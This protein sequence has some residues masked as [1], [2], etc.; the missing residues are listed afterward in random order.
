[1]FGKILSLPL[2]PVTTCGKS[3]SQMF[4]RALNLPLQT[5]S[6]FS[7]AL[8]L[9]LVNMINKFH[10]MSSNSVLCTV[11]S[12]WPSIYLNNKNYNTSF[13]T[14][15]FYRSWIKEKKSEFLLRVNSSTRLGSQFVLSPS[16]E[17]RH[18]ANQNAIAIN[19]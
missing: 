12:T 17:K 13:L 1:M 2:K 4:D 8:A 15:C 9:Y 11:K 5:L 10:H 14:I 16:I 18:F 3:P 19:E 7:K 6:I